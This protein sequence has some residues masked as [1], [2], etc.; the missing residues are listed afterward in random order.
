[1]EDAAA[2]VD[3][4]LRYEEGGEERKKNE[5][6]GADD[7][8]VGES[9][10][11][12]N[13][14]ENIHA[15]ACE[16][17]W[18]LALEKCID[19]L[20]VQVDEREMMAGNCYY[21]LALFKTRRYIDCLATMED[22]QK[23]IGVTNDRELSMDMPFLMH[24]MKALCAFYLENFSLAEELLH[25]L[26]FFTKDRY[27]AGG[28]DDADCT[29]DRTGIPSASLDASLDMQANQ[30][31][32]RN[33]WGMRASL[34]CR[35]LSNVYL[36]RKRYTLALHWIN[37]MVQTADCE[38]LSLSLAVQVLLSIGEVEEASALL[39][40]LRE[41]VKEDTCDPSGHENQYDLISTCEGLVKF[42]QEDYKG[43]TRC[44][45][46]YMHK[47]KNNPIAAN[48]LAVCHMYGQELSIAIQILEE[49]TQ[50]GLTSQ[51]GETSVLNLCS[52]YE[53]ST[54]SATE[55]KKSLRRWIISNGP[56]DFDLAATKVVFPTT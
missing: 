51:L 34:V 11:R 8:V 36:S 17:S 20:Q 28:L 14:L 16:G 30:E 44:F 55:K 22:V 1:M 56:D 10:G 19:F 7:A 13:G 4:P 21:A 37:L 47:H 15:L 39:D 6:N 23:A 26:F 40:D 29:G 46:A 41:S 2:F 9:G 27:L 24:L 49:S 45:A 33:I 32:R 31:T 18:K 5:A 38:T 12:K 42:T 25:N 53:L 52:M 48:N 54:L 43:A 50:Q 3:H 35:V